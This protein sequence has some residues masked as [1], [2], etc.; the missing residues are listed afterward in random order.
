ME[1]CYF[2]FTKR[3]LL[4]RIFSRFLNCKN[5]TKSRKATYIIFGEIAKLEWQNFKLVFFSNAKTRNKEVHNE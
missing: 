2:K 3:T 5:C 4:H 1:D